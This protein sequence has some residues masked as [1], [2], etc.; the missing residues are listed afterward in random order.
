MIRSASPN[1]NLASLEIDQGLVSP[2]FDASKYE[3]ETYINN[4][5]TVIDLTIIPEDPKAS[6][7]ILDNPNAVVNPTDKNKVKISKVTD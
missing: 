6:Y 3:F 4:S 2:E 7:V 5:N 1:F